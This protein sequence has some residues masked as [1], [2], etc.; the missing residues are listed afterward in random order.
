MMDLKKSNPTLLFLGFFL[1]VAFLNDGFMGTDE[2]WNAMVKYLPAQTATYTDLVDQTDVKSPLQVM[3]MHFGSQLA[4]KLGVFHPYDQYRFT[5]LFITILN[6]LIYI[7]SFHIIQSVKLWNMGN[8][9]SSERWQNLSHTVFIYLFTFYFASSFALT[10][11]MFES[12]AAPWIL[13][14][15]ALFY[16]YTQD[17]KLNDIV[18]ATVAVSL[19]FVLRQQAGI[20]A[21]TIPVLLILGKDKRGFLVS[22]AVGVI[23]FL[24][25]GIPDIYLRGSF[26]HSLWAVLT[27]N[28]DHGHE[29]GNGS[30]LFYPLLLMGLSFFPFLWFNNGGKSFARIVFKK[31]NYAWVFIALFVALHSYF[32]QKFE[33]FMVSIIP[34]LIVL[35]TP[36]FT[37]LVS[38]WPQKKAALITMGVLNIFILI[39]ASF[40]PSQKNIINMALFIDRHSEIKTIYNLEK[41]LEWIPEKFIFRNHDY[42]IVDLSLAAVKDQAEKN[43]QAAIIVND[44]IFQEQRDVLKNFRVVDT[45]EVN[46]IERLAYRF[47]KKNNIRRAPLHV[48]SNCPRLSSRYI[49]E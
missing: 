42:S 37:R 45:F 3:P 9:Y 14:S 48:L 10:R 49:R 8:E 26:H 27:Y 24:L 13:L 16:R 47:N 32:P 46:W 36:F 29:Y 31:L 34:L 15:M 20:G 38:L 7:W 30:I 17:G 6:L 1:L 11:P 28:V 5:I 4:L 33:R 21:L 23:C 40:F 18:N 25:A 43:C 22:S 19:A 44:F 41:T 39:N 12:L 35:M 2:Y